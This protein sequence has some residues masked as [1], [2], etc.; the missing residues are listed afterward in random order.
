[1]G[2]L[3]LLLVG[4]VFGWLASIMTQPAE[5]GDDPILIASGAVSAVVA[6]LAVYDGSV[7][8]GLSPQAF[9]AAALAS[10]I[11]IACV[12]SIRRTSAG[13]GKD[14]SHLH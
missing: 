1:M 7:I 5:S 14:S 6:G 12:V 8:T 11:V 3:L 4:A 10:A 9:V 13:T 2:L